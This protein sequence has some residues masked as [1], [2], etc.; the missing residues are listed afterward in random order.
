NAMQYLGPTGEQYQANPFPGT[1]QYQPQYQPQGYQHAS[2]GQPQ[3]H[4]GPGPQNFVPA[5]YM[6]AV[7]DLPP[8]LEYLTQ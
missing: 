2:A 4:P 1:V 8:G 6:A 7:P 5:P 3:A